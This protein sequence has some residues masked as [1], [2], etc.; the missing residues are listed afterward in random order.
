MSLTN[1]ISKLLHRKPAHAD[2][3]L[4]SFLVELQQDKGPV[5]H[6]MRKDS[7]ELKANLIHVLHVPKPGEY[8]IGF[9][10]GKGHL[11][12]KKAYFPEA[13]AYI[14]GSLSEEAIPAGVDAEGIMR[15]PVYEDRLIVERIGSRASYEEALKLINRFKNS[16][17]DTFR[18]AARLK[19]KKDTIPEEPGKKHATFNYIHKKPMWP[20][21][22]SAAA[23][24]LFATAGT[25][26]YVD[27]CIAEDRKQR[28]YENS[29]IRGKDAEYDE[30]LKRKQQLEENQAAIERSKK[31]IE[32][33]LRK[34]MI[35]EQERRRTDAEYRKQAQER[36][37]EQKEGI[38]KDLKTTLQ[39]RGIEADI[40]NVIWEGYTQLNGENWM[41]TIFTIESK[42]PAY[43][44]RTEFY[45]SKHSHGQ[46][47]TKIT[48]WFSLTKDKKHI[49]FT[50]KGNILHPKDMTEAENQYVQ[51]FAQKHNLAN[52]R[53][54]II[55][56]IIEK[57]GSHRAEEYKGRD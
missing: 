14:M 57:R 18:K 54:D 15:E 51:D 34:E 50:E 49:T 33:A 55:D 40:S 36:V 25:K 38:R 26:M 24:A 37:N 8:Q 41:N 19:E 28:E 39:K 11:N 23:F 1:L 6:L 10:R 16:E 22:L 35:K 2:P 52:L 48:T 4:I 53:K 3:D 46:A 56:T 27:Y 7:L 13:G 21:V 29:I 17:Q 9:N 5:Q 31:G 45:T 47:T 12:L 30:S 42:E 44:M 32:D 20:R 43:T